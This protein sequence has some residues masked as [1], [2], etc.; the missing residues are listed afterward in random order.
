[1]G[2]FDDLFASQ[3]LTYP[4]NLKHLVV[5][6]HSHLIPAIDDG[7]NSFE[8]ALVLI[9]HLHELG[10]KKI[11]T[12]PHVKQDYYRNTPE[13]ILR[14][15]D[16]LRHFVEQAEIDVEIEAAAEYL[17]DDGF[18]DKIKN[19]NLMTFGDR[20]ILVELS[21]YDPHPNLSS[22]VFNLQIDGYKVIL[23]HPE[24]YTYWLNDF[25]KFEELKNRGV[26]FQA[27][28]ISFGGVHSSPQ[29]KIIERLVREDMIEFLGTD[30]HNMLTFEI[31]RAHV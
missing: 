31:G 24:R 7:V 19:G 28:I 17:I 3:R 9:Q 29:Q 8:E 21:Y 20:Y 18:E 13:I 10:I 15:C 6:L 11:I 25:K 1:M 22:I 4:M 5:D 23:A 12:T 30:M 2:L 14:G 16:S 26:Y 27:N